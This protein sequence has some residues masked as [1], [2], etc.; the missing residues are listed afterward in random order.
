MAWWWSP[1]KHARKLVR[2]SREEIVR[3]VVLSPREP[4]RATLVECVIKLPSLGPWDSCGTQCVGLVLFQLA[5]EPPSER[6]TQRGLACWQA[7]EPQEKSPCY[8]CLPVGLHPHYTS[9][10][11]LFIYCACVVSLIIS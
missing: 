2:C 5:T 4:Q 10:Y 7:R 6:S 11:L 8:P 9:L 3:G 1:S